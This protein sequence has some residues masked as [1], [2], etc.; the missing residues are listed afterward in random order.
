MRYK[1]PTVDLEKNQSILDCPLTKGFNFLK[2]VQKNWIKYLAFVNL[3]RGI[4][5]FKIQIFLTKLSLLSQNLS[6]PKI[7]INLNQ[8]LPKKTTK[9]N[10]FLMLKLTSHDNVKAA[11]H[12]KHHAI[13]FILV[14]TSLVSLMIFMY[15]WEKKI[16]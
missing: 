2:M 10:M 4:W 14:G 3:T 6:S 12:Q 15:P 8:N 11:S 1:A 16:R 7:L 9:R 5:D 13:L